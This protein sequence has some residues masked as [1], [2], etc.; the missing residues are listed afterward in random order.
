[1]SYTITTGHGTYHG[2]TLK[3]AQ[4]AVKQGEAR[5]EVERKLRGERRKLAGLRAEA[6]AWRI[7]SY[8]LDGQTIADNLNW[9]YRGITDQYCGVAHRMSTEN[10]REHFYDV[11]TADGRATLELYAYRVAGSIENASGFT[12]AI[13]IEDMDRPGTPAVIHA[14][15]VA[16]DQVV[17]EGI[18][19]LT[20]ASFHHGH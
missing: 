6:Q 10:P 18:I 1:M 2:E 13:A 17:I 3:A 8:A 7:V 11:E 16:E 9:T 15:G 20:L 5:A 12:I 4:R 14:V 19:G